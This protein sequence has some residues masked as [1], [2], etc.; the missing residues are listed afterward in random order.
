MM[1]V[2][3]KAISD[4]GY[5]VTISTKQEGIWKELERSEVMN[6]DRAYSEVSRLRNFYGIY[7]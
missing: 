7:E 1:S 6:F 4:Y 5:V 2:G 3:L